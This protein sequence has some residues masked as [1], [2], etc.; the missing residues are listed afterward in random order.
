MMG[1]LEKVE[2]LFKWM[3]FFALTCDSN[4]WLWWESNVLAMGDLHVFWGH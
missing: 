3:F 1:D 4:A 2:K